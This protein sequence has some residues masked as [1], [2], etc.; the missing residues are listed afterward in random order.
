MASKV[1]VFITNYNMPERSDALYEYIDRHSAWETDIYLVDNGSD[2]QPP[3]VHT[4][5][6]MEKNRQTTAG[7]LTGLKAAQKVGKY[8][9]YSFM[10]TSADFERIHQDPISPMAEFLEEN[11]EAVG[12]HA[13]LTADSTT[14]WNHLL[15]RGGNEPRRTWFFD[16]IFSM[17]RADWFDSIGWFDPDLRYAWGIDLETCWTARQQG[18]G[19]YVH[20]GVKIRKITDIAYG[21]NRM[22]MSADERRQRAGENMAIVLEQKY[23]PDW[24]NIMTNQFVESEWR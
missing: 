13:A 3:A 5:T 7:W 19:L 11:P 24:W 20:E 18:R 1:A 6:W 8:L 15:T 21:M 4:T 17:Y 16:N 22:N 9:A 12:V 2:I 23:G 10:I 14:S